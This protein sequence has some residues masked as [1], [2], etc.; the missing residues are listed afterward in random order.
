M[1]KG[2]GE[3]II[4]ELASLAGKVAVVTG[5]GG[6]LGFQM[7]LCLLE[8]GAKVI[9]LGQD[10]NKVRIL[11]E[12]FGRQ[13][14]FIKID[15]NDK[16]DIFSLDKKL[17]ES[18]DIL[19]NNAYSWPKQVHLENLEWDDVLNTFITGA[20][21]PLFLS[22]MA[23][24]KMKKRGGS[25]INIASMYGIVSPDFRIYRTSGMG[26]AIHYGA[27]KAALI[28]MTKY[29]AIMGGPL[30]I[31][32]NAISPGPFSRP[33]TFDNGK[34]W[35]RE[36]L[37]NKVP[38]KRIGENWELKGVLALLASDMGSYITGQNLSVDGGWTTW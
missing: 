20:V 35:F 6:H 13:A 36:E 4:E 18:I 32:V 23:F 12:K 27:S 9:I 29:L 2:N 28:Q 34:E 26:N 10:K 16:G 14:T 15:L 33:G 31:R 7:S 17:P 25:I 21:S 37:I 11:K 8:L 5:G 22:K 3:K 24:S 1:K 38:L 19:V 30:N